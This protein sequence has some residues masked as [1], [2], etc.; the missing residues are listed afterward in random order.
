MLWKL[1]KI[2]LKARFFSF[3]QSKKKK[4]SKGKIV[5]MAVLVLYCVVVFFG[6]FG[7]TFNGMAPLLHQLN[8]DWGY[9]TLAFLIAFL[10]SL[11]TVAFITYQEIY[12]AKDNELLMSLP[13]KPRDI[14]LSRVFTVL[15]FSILIEAI[16]L[17]P[18]IVV[19][20][21]NYSLPLMG[22]INFILLYIGLS[23]LIIAMSS[24]VSYIIALVMPKFGRFKNLVIIAVF[25]LAFGAYMLAAFQINH[26]I[27]MF[28]ASGKDLIQA[29]REALPPLYYLGIAVTS[30]DLLG[31]FMNLLIFVVP[32]VIMMYIL[33]RNFINLSIARPKTKK[34]IYRGGNTKKDN[35]V[36]ALI[37]KEYKHYT[38]N[39]MVFLNAAMGIIFEVVIL[40]LF[41]FNL[42][43]LRPIFEAEILRPYLLALSIAVIIYVSSL[44]IMSSS[45]ISIE[46]KS[47]YILRSLPLKTKTILWSKFL[48]HFVFSTPLGL[49]VSIIFGLV[50]DFNLV[51]FLAL[52]LVPMTFTVF[53]DLLGLLT[54][55]LKPRFDWTNEVSCVKQSLPVAITIL[56]SMAVAMAIV[57]IY[58]WLLTEM[59]I[60]LY[61]AILTLIFVVV[62]FLMALALNTWGVKR[63][64]TL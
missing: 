26:V 13:I 53:V 6:L 45:M 37:K 32:F 39:A 36:F 59:D 35:V 64:E 38:N 56:T 58:A 14:L 20:L 40:V 31:L 9:F 46:G 43:N 12:K 22:I 63:F 44:N 1:I 18:A 21:L 33:A 15:V 7:M 52:I 57:G 51:E 11:I 23:F 50:F 17:I 19:Y 8:L 2:R 55:L 25:V 49:V 3:N 28:I 60:N 48:A 42:E 54:N 27:E 41:I 29:I 62:D 34:H 16:V 61:I 47:F 5:G 4:Y 10:L 24:L 30:G